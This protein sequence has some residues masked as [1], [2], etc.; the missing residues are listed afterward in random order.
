MIEKLNGIKKIFYNYFHEFLLQLEVREENEN[1]VSLYELF[2]KT[3]ENFVLS[4]NLINNIG[5]TDEKIFYFLELYFFNKNLDLFDDYSIIDR[6]LDTT[7][8]SAL[9]FDNFDNIE[10]L[11]MKLNEYLFNILDYTDCFIVLE[12]NT[13]QKLISW[14]MVEDN[15]SNFFKSIN[16]CLFEKSGDIFKRHCFPLEANKKIYIYFRSSNLPDLHKRLEKNDLCRDLILLFYNITKNLYIH[17]FNRLFNIDAYD[18]NGIGWSNKEFAIDRNYFSS[19]HILRVFPYDD[20]KEI[21][22]L[23][24]SDLHLK[25]TNENEPFADKFLSEFYNVKCYNVLEKNDVKE[26]KKIDIIVITGDAIN[27]GY[28]TQEI[29]NNYLYAY[30]E[31]QT[32]GKVLLGN[33]WQKRIFVIPGNHDYGMINDMGIEIK[34]RAFKGSKVEDSNEEFKKFIFF[35][36]IFDNKSLNKTISKIEKQK[37]SLDIMRVKYQPEKYLAFCPF[38]TACNANTDISNK[39]SIHLDKDFSFPNDY[40]IFLLMHHTP[41]FEINYYRDKF[42]SEY[43]DY[44]SLILGFESAEYKEVMK[45]LYSNSLENVKMLFSKHEADIKEKLKDTNGEEK[46]LLEDIKKA[47]NS[48]LSELEKKVEGSSLISQ[49]IESEK[50]QENYTKALEAI[51]TKIS[52]YNRK[53]KNCLIMG[54]HFHSQRFQKCENYK[55][56]EVGKTFLKN[57]ESG[58]EKT[59]F[60]VVNILTKDNSMKFYSSVPMDQTQEKDKYI[61]SI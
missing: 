57:K 7:N 48:L 5:L 28:S 15:Y 59:Y 23:H 52:S 38:N 31:I 1:L 16:N 17:H 61:E 11:F 19:S 14:N 36:F 35:H 42:S 54:G 22:I 39:V 51:M 9:S 58:V 47:N 13:M 53:E 2:N 45:S 49:F 40:F 12:D 6:H 21:N 29:L 44:G 34:D 32:I 4:Q 41:L 37:Q 43:F 10:K 27:A 26:F 25:K 50:D 55:V 46:Q 20:R 30:N 18:I 60:A 24:I 33:L 56:L 8:N 3:K